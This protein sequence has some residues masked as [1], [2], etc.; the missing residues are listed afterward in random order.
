M[1]GR[2]MFGSSETPSSGPSFW[3][4]VNGSV[5]QISPTTLLPPSTLL[6]LATGC[7]CLQSKSCISEESWPRPPRSRK[8]RTFWVSTR[9]RSGAGERPTVSDSTLHFHPPSPCILQGYSS[10]DLSG[11]KADHSALKH[12]LLKSI[13]LQNGTPIAFCIDTDSG[14]M[15]D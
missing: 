9:R 3:A 6:Q 8:R 2:G 13:G 4:V 15:E 5:W 11:F 14:Q 10:P 7:P 12:I 1:P